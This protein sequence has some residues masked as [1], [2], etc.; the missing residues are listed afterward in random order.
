MGRFANEE[1]I[2]EQRREEQEQVLARS[3]A[4]EK[5]KTIEKWAT[6]NREE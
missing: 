5:Y 3:L 1:E 2:V 6:A 4:A